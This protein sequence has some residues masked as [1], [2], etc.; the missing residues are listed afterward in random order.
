MRKREKPLYGIIVAALLAVLFIIVSVPRVAHETIETEAQDTIV[1][2]PF[3]ISPYDSLFKVYADTLGWDWKLLA[4]VAYVESKF[5]TAAVSE[6]GAKGL[7][8]LMPV[9]ALA[10]GI[11]EGCEKDPEQSIRG[12]VGYFA[13]LSHMFRRIPNE[14]RIHFILASY[15]AGFGHIQDAMRLAQKYGKNRYVWY[16]NVET[17]LLLKNDSVYYTDSLCRNGKFMGLETCSFVKKVTRKH[18]DYL[19][20]EERHMQ[21][22]PTLVPLL[23]DTLLVY[24]EKTGQKDVSKD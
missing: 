2:V 11:P 4:A 5:D 16:D 19:L 20:R 15:N 1:P 8:Q 23:S 14:E 21:L 22:P 13:Y 3:C 7:M 9:T 6:V 10:M 24:S 17:Y 12:A 18:K